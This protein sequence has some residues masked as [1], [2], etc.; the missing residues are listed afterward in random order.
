MKEKL[1]STLLHTL[2]LIVL[3]GITYVMVKV[4]GLEFPAELMVI[5]LAALAK[6]TRVSTKD[7]VND[8]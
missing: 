4:L 1:F 3:M 5:I 7:I 2:E 6:F 8:R